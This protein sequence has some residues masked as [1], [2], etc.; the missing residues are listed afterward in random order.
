VLCSGKLYYDL[1]NARLAHGQTDVALIRLEEFY[2]FPRAALARLLEP[3]ANLRTLVWAQEENKNQ[4]A[5]AFVRDELA[6][7]C[8]PGGALHDVARPNTAS[9]ATSSLVIYQRQQRELVARALG[10][11]G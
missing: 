11:G 6:A 10:R 1:H 8:P 9:G 5:W 3:Y 2:P 7:L 4:G